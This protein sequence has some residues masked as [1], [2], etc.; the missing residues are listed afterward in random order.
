MVDE[1]SQ[2]SQLFGPGSSLLLKFLP[3]QFSTKLY[4]KLD[5]WI[6]IIPFSF[7]KSWY[8]FCR[9]SPSSPPELRTPGR[10]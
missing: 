5:K 3:F 8:C 4:L 2:C 9:R 6:S 10:L 7:F 1:K